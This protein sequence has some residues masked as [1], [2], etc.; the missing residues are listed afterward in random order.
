MKSANLL[1]GCLPLHGRGEDPDEI[2]AA[3]DDKRL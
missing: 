1:V 3:L 2:V